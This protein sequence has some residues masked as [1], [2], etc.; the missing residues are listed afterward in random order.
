MTSRQVTCLAP[1]P[2]T[3]CYTGWVGAGGGGLPGGMTSI[4]SV[5]DQNIMKG[6]VQA[7]SEDFERGAVFL[8][9]KVE[10][11]SSF[12]G[13]V[14]YYI[15]FLCFWVYFIAKVAPLP[16]GRGR[17]PPPF[18]SLTTAMKFH[19]SQAPPQENNVYEIICKE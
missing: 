19:L 5:I 7:C 17:R 16:S 9:E 2:T 18:Y 12:L 11:F 13:G 15:G 6:T 10:C 1:A 3:I 4:L 14:F 8:G